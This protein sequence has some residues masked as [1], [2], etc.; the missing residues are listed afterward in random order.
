MVNCEPLEAYR[1]LEEAELVGCWAHVRRK[2]FEA[3]PKQT[4]KSSL[5][6]KGLA[7]CD[8]L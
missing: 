7:Y 5:G 8:Q 4:D 2:F 6:A 3:P 1:Q